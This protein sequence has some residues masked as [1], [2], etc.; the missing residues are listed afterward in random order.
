M[1]N[2]R[3]WHRMP[4]LTSE[5]REC[6]LAAIGSFLRGRTLFLRGFTH[7]LC[8]CFSLTAFRRA[9]LRSGGFEGDSRVRK[10]EGQTARLSQQGRRAGVKE[11][12]GRDMRTVDRKN[13]KSNKVSKNNTP[14]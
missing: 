11:C 5:G 3:N 10:R 2:E 9:R 6:K 7:L 8:V 4:H 13:I 14:F 1:E 12:A